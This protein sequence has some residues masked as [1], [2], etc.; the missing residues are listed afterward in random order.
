VFGGILKDMNVPIPLSTQIILAISLY[1]NK[2][3]YLLISGIFLL[4]LTLM[5]YLKTPKGKKQADNLLFVIPILKDLAQKVIV[6]R[7]CRTLA[8]LLHSGVPIL[9]ALEVVERTIGNAA[10]KEEIDKCKKNVTDGR[11]LTESFRE[12]KVFPPMVIQMMAVGEHS[13][14]LDELLVKVSDYYDGEVAEATD[15]LPK[16][17]EPIMIVLLGIVVGAVVMGVLLPM[18]SVMSSIGS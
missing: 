6:A 9:Q 3:W 17:I 11:S 4:C 18:F 14:N 15:R 8:N 16:L 10:L 1:F 2:Y 5:F 7:F 13:G 12:G